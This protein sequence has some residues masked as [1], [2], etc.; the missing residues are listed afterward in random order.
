M[1]VYMFIYINMIKY[2]YMIIR[3]YNIMYIYVCVF[4]CVFCSHTAVHI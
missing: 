3:V 2:A 4:V 1:C